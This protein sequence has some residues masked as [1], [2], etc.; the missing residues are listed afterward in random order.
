VRGI[1]ARFAANDAR[2]L[3]TS[4]NQQYGETIEVTHEALIRNW[5]QLRD[6][7]N[8]NREALRQKQKIEQ[9]AEEWVSQGR[10]KEYLLQGRP[11]RDAR[12][13]M[14]TAQGETAPSNLAT[15][16][17]QYS[18]GKQRNDR[19]K[20]FVISLLIPTMLASSIFH[21]GIVQF[22]DWK[23]HQGGCQPDFTSRFLLQYLLVFRYGDT[24]SG[25]NLCGKQ[26][27]DIDFSKGN[28]QLW[29]ADFSYANLSGATLEN[30]N[31]NEAKFIGTILLGAHL[32]KARLIG[33]DLR[34]ADLSNTHLKNAILIRVKIQKDIKTQKDTNFK[35][36]DIKN[37]V[38]IDTDLSSALGLTLEQVS[39]AK[40]CGS[41]FPPNI[42]I[43]PDKDCL[44]PEVLKFLPIRKR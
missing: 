1:I 27:P 2:F 13:F 24:L 9:A 37:T 18:Q 36:A 30:A 17:V 31:L 33:T 11:L 16:F 42:Q 12:E 44:D 29:R 39:Q 19:L 40:I 32:Q 26:L 15:Q 34:G 10:S 41:K 5:S 22:A 3:T 4:L 21:F 6:W 7:L 8:G 43:D 38:I 25:I 14:K 28:T 35:G 23:L 20:R